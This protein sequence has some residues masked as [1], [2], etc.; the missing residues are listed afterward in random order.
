MELAAGTKLHGFTVRYVQ[1]IPEIKGTLY[2]MEYDKNGADLI[3]LDRADD[4]KTFCIGFKTIPQDDTGVFHIL[5]HSVLNGSRKYPV[6]E[7]FVEL[8]KSSLQTFLNAMTYPDKT[9]YPVSSRNDQDFLNL[10]DVYLDATL[11]PLC[12]TDPHAYRQEGWH[13]EMESTD[14]PVI[15]NGVVFNEMKGAYADPDTTAQAEMNKLLFPDTCYRWESGG[16][17][18]HIPDL[19]YE[20]YQA[21]H[22]RFYHPSNARIILDGAVNLD[23]ALAKLDEYLAPF[24][25]I[26]P[27]ADIPIQAPVTPDE[28]TVSY[29]IG[30]NEDPTDKVILCGGWVYGTYA[31]TELT[32]A[33]EVL[34]QLLAGSNESPICK[35]ILEGGLAQDVNFYAMSGMQ[36]NFLAFQARNTTL[37]N[38]ERVWQV[39]ENTL[40]DLVKNGLDHDRLHAILNRQEFGARERDYGGMPRGLVAALQTYNTWL[41]GGDPA[42]ALRF[43]DTFASLRKKIDEGWFETLIEKYIL[44]SNHCAKLTMVPS[45]TIGEEKRAAEA[46]RLAAVKATWDDA[47]IKAVMDEFA[48]LRQRQA[49]PDSPEQLASLPV[50]NLSDIPEKAPWTACT[51]STIAGRPVLH[52]DLDTDGITYL[53]LFFDLSDLTIEE[54][55]QVPMLCHVLGELATEH[56][57]SLALHSFIEGNLGRFSVDSGNFCRFGDLKSAMPQLI[58]SMGLLEGGKEAAKVVLKEVLQT[59]KFD[60]IQ[61]YNMVRQARIGSEQQ[62]INRGDGMGVTMANASISAKGVVDDALG[63]LSQHRYLQATEKSFNDN[64]ED[65]CAGMADLCR[66]IITK[67]RVLVGI[68]GAMDEDWI[69]SILADLPDGAM[70]PQAEYAIAPAKRLGLQIPANVGFTARVGNAYAVADQLPGASRVVSNLL[71]YDYLWNEVRVKGG[72]YG[73]GMRVGNDGSLMFT[74]FRDPNCPQSLD[75]FAKATAALR[76]AAASGQK[77]DKYII[78]TIGDLDPLL[79]PRITGSRAVGLYLSGMTEEKNQALRTAVLHTTPKDLE[80]MA[81]LI[82]K[83]AE[84]SSTVVVGGQAALDACGDKLTAREVL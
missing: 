63:G 67:D 64:G 47:Q 82:D 1:Q 7:P 74:S 54:L 37:E 11:H 75:T 33:L 29:E 30:P 19:T 10:M 51:E 17:P 39:L 77:L 46:A 58:V 57:D 70:G 25:R 4:N 35:P 16:E 53:N 21:S 27:D 32:I 38:K 36:Q 8:L 69:A 14:G 68:T 61:V 65:I 80:D 31:D 45:K 71:T 44:H 40:A 12:A 20:N 76:A 22:A 52:Y 62:I 23:A 56:Y 26:D 73:T 72:A 78:S 55:T 24:D 59:S 79:T 66:R 15:Y 83:S 49:T 9:V 6:K 3:W 81:D 84:V 2:R 50:L 60:P 18:S 34:C 48:A 13:Y 28:C 43:D 41:Y 5:E 42:D